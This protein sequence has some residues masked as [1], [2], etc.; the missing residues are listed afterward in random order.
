M[1][2]HGVDQSFVDNLVKYSD[3]WWA[4]TLAAL[5]SSRDTGISYFIVNQRNYDV[6][7]HPAIVEQVVNKYLA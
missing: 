2:H 1:G 7:A 3:G 5:P 6:M 4:D